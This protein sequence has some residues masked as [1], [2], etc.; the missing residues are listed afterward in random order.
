MVRFLQHFQ[1]NA[2]TYFRVQE[3]SESKSLEFFV[4]DFWYEKCCCGINIRQLYMVKIQFCTPLNIAPA[5][6]DDFLIGKQIKLVSVGTRRE[7]GVGRFGVAS[8]SH[9]YD[10]IE[11]AR[12]EQQ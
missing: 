2:K 7:A 12:Q 1:C 6:L 3:T 5:S 10:T 9:G 4:R 8:A 11:R